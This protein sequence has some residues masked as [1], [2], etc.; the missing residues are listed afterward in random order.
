M[1][2]AYDWAL[3]KRIRKIQFDLAITSPLAFVAL[4]IHTVEMLAT[5]IVA[6]AIWHFRDIEHVGDTGGPGLCQRRDEPQRLGT[7][8][9]RV[10]AWLTR[11]V[12]D[13]HPSSRGS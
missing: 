11:Q 1:N 12:R 6:L 2:L 3:S 7:A 4:F 8:V 10:S 5:W 13:P 9:D